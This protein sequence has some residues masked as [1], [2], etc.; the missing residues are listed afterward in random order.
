MLMVLTQLRR[1]SSVPFKSYIQSKVTLGTTTRRHYKLRVKSGAR[2]INMIS[3]PLPSDETMLDLPSR[4]R[5][6]RV[7]P[8]LIVDSLARPIPVR[9][10]Q[11]DCT[12]DPQEVSQPSCRMRR[13]TTTHGSPLPAAVWSHAKVA[14]AA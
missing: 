11:R 12:D 1:M 3:A 10:S 7:H 5:R 13:D 2:S 4:W 8:Q 6:H 14:A 9:E